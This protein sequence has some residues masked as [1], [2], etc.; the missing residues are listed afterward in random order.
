MPDQDLSEYL[1]FLLAS[2]NRRMHIGLAQSIAA[3][4]VTE[5]QWRILQV[6]SDEQGRSMGGL[7]ELVLMNHPALTKNIDRLVSRNLVQRAA[8][9]QDNRKV[10]VYISD[11]GLEVVSRLKVSVDAHH[12]ALEEAMGPRKVEQLKKLLKCFIEESAAG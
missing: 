5:E 1:A 11:L 7:A 10:L 12:G 9:A 3:E 8:D 2:A 4:E 6:L